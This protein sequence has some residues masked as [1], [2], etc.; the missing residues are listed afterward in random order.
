MPGQTRSLILLIEAGVS[1]PLQV[2][3]PAV[4]KDDEETGHWDV[5]LRRVDAGADLQSVQLIE[6]VVTAGTN[7]RRGQQ[8]SFQLFAD[9]NSDEGRQG[10]S[11]EL[12]LESLDSERMF[13][14]NFK[15]DPSVGQFSQRS[16][17][18]PGTAGY[19]R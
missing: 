11:L 16:Q 14:D 4:T 8:R 13:R 18:S 9:G 7:N 19:S 15:V 3:E 1:V 6:L 10:L 2:T 12:N 5:A 17:R